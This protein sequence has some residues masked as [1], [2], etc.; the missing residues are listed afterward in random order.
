MDVE[1]AAATEFHY[2]HPET[3]TLGAPLQPP[4]ESSEF[5]IEFVSVALRRLRRERRPMV[6]GIPSQQLRP[7]EAKL[8]L[9]LP[10]S[11][12]LSINSRNGLGSP[13]AA[14]HA[15]GHGLG[16]ARK[17]TYKASASL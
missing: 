6:P 4:D 3:G 1:H 8:P 13:A 15:F 16:L 2:S 14:S 5:G 10:H 17:G 12:S 7:S 11:N 9:R